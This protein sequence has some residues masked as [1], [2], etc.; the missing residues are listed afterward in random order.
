MRVAAK[1]RIRIVHSWESFIALKQVWH[2]GAFVTAR[3]AGGGVFM[4]PPKEK[5]LFR[6]GRRL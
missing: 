4:R 1:N 2:D 6:H 3:V 5:C